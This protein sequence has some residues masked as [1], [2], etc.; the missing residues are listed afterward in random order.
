MRR[1]VRASCRR[2]AHCLAFPAS[3]CSPRVFDG[4]LLLSKSGCHSH[5]LLGYT[6]S[7]SLLDVP[8]EIVEA[9]LKLAL[10]HT[11]AS[12]LSILLVSR[13]IYDVSLPILHANPR[14]RSQRSLDEFIRDGLTPL[15][16]VPTSVTLNLS[17]VPRQGLAEALGRV[18]TRCRPIVSGSTG[19]SKPIGIDDEGRLM[20]ERLALR[21]HTRRNDSASHL[22]E[23]L[24]TIK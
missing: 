1:I 14:M 23:V 21:C 13:A 12:P 10:R 6:Q 9:I 5:A 11:S 20:L 22:E 4:V 3:A 8:V 19:Q 18:F 17:G 15:L 7:M 24:Q 16:R 2:Q